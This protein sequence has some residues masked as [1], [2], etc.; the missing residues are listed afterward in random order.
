[1]GNQFMGTDN[2]PHL[3]YL[4]C[5]GQSLIIT[6][7]S[8]WTFYTGENYTG[9]AV[10]AWSTETDSKGKKTLNVGLYKTMA[11]MYTNTIRSVRK[12]CHTTTAME[13]EPL[14]ATQQAGNGATG[15]FMV[16]KP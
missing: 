4:C 15:E 1:M 6:G 8:K 3:K 9:S 7:T 13:V 2:V 14:E 12:G 11:P 5:K 16:Q 10:C